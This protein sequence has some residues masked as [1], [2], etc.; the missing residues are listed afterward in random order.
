MCEIGQTLN[1]L[2]R[3]QMKLRLM[4]DIRVD[5]E[6]CK[7]EGINYKDYLLELKDMIDGFL[8][9]KEDKS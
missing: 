2:A 1:Q 4:Q 8:R 7:L 3:E 6:V 5:I 9:V